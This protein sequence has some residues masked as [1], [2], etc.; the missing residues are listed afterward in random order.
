[1]LPAIVL[2]LW[3]NLFAVLGAGTAAAGAI[4]DDQR[5]RRALTLMSL[6]GLLTMVPATWQTIEVWSAASRPTPG[7]FNNY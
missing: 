4:A 6:I 2:L 5:R 3:A 1:M 7:L